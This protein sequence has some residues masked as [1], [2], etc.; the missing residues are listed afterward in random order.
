MIHWVSKLASFTFLST[1][2][3]RLKFVLIGPR[4]TVTENRTYNVYDKLPILVQHTKQNISGLTCLNTTFH[5]KTT[6]VIMH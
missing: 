6:C 5:N 1:H 2:V 3:F 4:L